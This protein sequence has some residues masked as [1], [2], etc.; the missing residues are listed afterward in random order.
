LSDDLVDLRSLLAE[1]PVTDE[2][3]APLSA[4][5]NRIEEKILAGAAANVRLQSLQVAV[6]ARYLKKSLPC[7]VC[8]RL[9][10]HTESCYLA[11]ATGWN[12]LNEHEAVVNENNE[13]R[14]ALARHLP[15]NGKLVKPGRLSLR[16]RAR[17]HREAER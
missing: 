16:D 10:V 15:H 9:G 17:L 6:D 2:E 13:L 11:A 1:L 12:L 8:N 14:A 3:L 5:V 7:P 4:I